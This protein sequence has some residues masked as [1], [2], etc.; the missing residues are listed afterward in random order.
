MRRIGAAKRVT[1]AD[2]AKADGTHVTTVSLAMRNSPRLARETRLRIQN[3]AEKMGYRPDPTL[4]ALVSYR[5]AVRKTVNP[6]VIA[7][8]TNW[9]T[10]WGWKHATAHPDFYRGAEAAANAMGFKLEHFWAREPDLTYQRLDGIL[11]ARGIHGVIVASY[12]REYDDYLEFN[13]E[14]LSAVKIDY[15]PHR[16]VLHNVTNNQFA[17]VSMAT[18]EA[19]K[20]GYARVGFV[21]HRG[22]DHSVDKGFSAGYLSVQQDIPEKDQIPA[23]IYPDKEPVE[24]WINER[25]DVPPG[26]ETF[27]AWWETHRPEVI[28]SKASFILPLLKELKIRVP[29]DVAYV[30]IFHDGQ[31]DQIAGVAQ[32]HETVGALA[33]E[34]LA[35]RLYQNKYG[36]PQVPTTTHVDGS[37]YPGP[38]LPMKK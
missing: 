31:D 14:H 3:L 19:L 10:R 23:L 32:N 15:L 20:Q 35:G 25:G 2:I 6:S 38:S 1:L 8:L 33:V 28:V 12:S 11:K 21:M 36:L 26:K 24:D 17:I 37:W 13:W 30:D 9:T 29:R 4:Q 22:W 27:Q 7:Y 34:I 18:R 5:K 16:P